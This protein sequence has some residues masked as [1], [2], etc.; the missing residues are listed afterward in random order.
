MVNITNDMRKSLS[1]IKP[2]YKGLVV[3]FVDMDKYLSLRIYENQIMSLS[4][5]QQLSFMEYLQLLRK[6]VESYGVTCH[7]EGAKGDPPRSIS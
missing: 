5:G 7:F 6:T 4:S 3:D 1:Q 2:P